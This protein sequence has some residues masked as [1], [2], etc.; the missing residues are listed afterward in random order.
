MEFPWNFPGYFFGVWFPTWQMLYFDLMK[1][2]FSYRSINMGI[3]WKYVLLPPWA[4]SRTKGAIITTMLSR[5]FSFSLAFLDGSRWRPRKM[6]VPPKHQKL[7]YVSLESYGDLGIPHFRE[8]PKMSRGSQHFSGR[9]PAWN[10]ENLASLVRKAMWEDVLCRVDQLQ[11]LLAK[12]CSNLTQVDRTD[13]WS[14]SSDEQCEPEL[15][16]NIRQRFQAI[17]RLPTLFL[18]PTCRPAR[19]E[20]TVWGWTWIQ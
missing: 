13:A 5:D 19:L 7:D 20:A 4:N 6:G 10:W 12:T 15:V 14:L 2:W 8:P 1:I 3:Y 18:T 11:G 9:L 16:L 17:H